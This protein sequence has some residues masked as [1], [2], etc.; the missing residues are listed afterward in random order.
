MSTEIFWRIF[1]T[2]ILAIGIAYIYIKYGITFFGGRR[3]DI[4]SHLEKAKEYENKA[5]E[6]YQEA[7]SELENARKEMREIREEAIK[8]A[9]AEKNL[10][11]KN[12]QMTAD[13]IVNAYLEHA[14]SE[15]DNHRKELLEE[16]I[17]KSFK[18]ANEKIKKEI[19]SAGDNKLNEN[20]LK[21]QEEGFA[22]QSNK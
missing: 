1:D 18:T 3:R 13:K 21:A 20:F 7:K 12:A 10:I 8:E 6:I 19:E 22:R 14:K 11:V 5:K 2:I 16:M 15:I 4:E 17:G 9:A